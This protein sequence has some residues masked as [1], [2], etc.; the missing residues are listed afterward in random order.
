M[1]VPLLRNPI[2]AAIQRGALQQ[3]VV[4]G[5]VVMMLEEPEENTRPPAEYQ[6]L[7]DESRADGLLIA[8]SR[9]GPDASSLVPAA[10][11][12]YLNRRGP[13]PGDDVV[14]DEEQAMCLFVEHLAELGHR[15]LAVI[16]GAREV[17][18][19]HRRTEAT[20]QFAASL[21]MSA[22]FQHEEDTEAGG[23]AAARLLLARAPIP[24]AIGVGNLS[25]LF[26]VVKALRESGLDVPGDISLVS[27]DEDQCLGYLDVPVTSISMPLAELGAAA[28]RALVA[29]VEGAHGSDV[30]VSDPLA[31]VRRGSTGPARR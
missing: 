25:Q 28:V 27:F 18:T 11:H 15:R 24:T 31:F 10:P 21:G 8:T 6:Y 20:R 17:D 9:R 16:D 13:R 29:R 12:V 7:V 19:V 30:M 23:Y 14:M 5:Y 3:A 2:W 4:S 1:V 26:G 22:S